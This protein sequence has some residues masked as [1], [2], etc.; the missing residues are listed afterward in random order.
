MSIRLVCPL[1][2]TTVTDGSEE[3]VPGSCPG[4]GAVYDG[5]GTSPLEAVTTALSSWGRADDPATYL[6]DLFRIDPDDPTAEA[7]IASDEREGFYR[8]WVFRR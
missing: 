1:C 8:W 4:C 2:R 3:P 6:G 7:A 5:G